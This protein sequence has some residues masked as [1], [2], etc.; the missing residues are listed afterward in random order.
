MSIKIIWK[1][2]QGIIMS[3]RFFCPHCW[4]EVNAQADS[5]GYCSYDLKKY[6]NLSYEEKLINALRHPVRENRMIAI[7]VLGKLRSRKALPM[8]AS[9]LETEEDFYIIRE[10]MLALEKIGG[11]ESKKILLCL[12]THKS[13][14][15][16][17]AVQQLCGVRID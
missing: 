5:C 15:I 3:S 12:K 16:R 13:R 7:Q 1:E 10:I 14:L 6:K 11:A 8:F 9:I 17:S 4:K 2:Y